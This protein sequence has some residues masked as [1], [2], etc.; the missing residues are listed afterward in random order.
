MI[1]AA[2]VKDYDECLIV[3]INCYSLQILETNKRIKDEIYSN[4][5]ADMYNQ[6]QK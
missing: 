1:K 3:C 6:L 5:L 4:Q 2:I